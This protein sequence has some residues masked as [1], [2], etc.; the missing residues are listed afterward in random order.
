[1]CLAP[2]YQHHRC[3]HWS[4][5]LCVPD[6]T[7]RS[8]YTID[9]SFYLHFPSQIFILNIQMAISQQWLLPIALDSLQPFKDMEWIIMIQ[10]VLVL[11]VSHDLAVIQ[12]YV[13]RIFSQNII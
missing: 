4:V 13:V 7:L 5:Y 6:I 2:R 11:A 9:A 8:I 1:M 10:R 12:E 3:F